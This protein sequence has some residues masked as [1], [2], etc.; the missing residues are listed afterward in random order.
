MVRIVFSR[1]VHIDVPAPITLD[2]AS[3]ST[4]APSVTQELEVSVALMDPASVEIGGT[5]SEHAFSESA[6]DGKHTCLTRNST[7]PTVISCG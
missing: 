5:S 6:L 1:L 3:E 4:Q 2:S 7:R